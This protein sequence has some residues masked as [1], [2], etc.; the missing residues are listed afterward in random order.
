MPSPFPLRHLVLLLIVAGVMFFLGLGRLPLIEPDEGRNAEV[1]REMLATGDLITPH[2]DTFVYLDKPAVYFWLVAGSFRLWGLD[3]WAARFPSALMA[4]GTMLLT[5]FLARRMYGGS[6]GVRAGII[7]ATTPLVIALSR[8]VIFDMTLVCLETAALVCFWLATASDYRRAWLEVGMFAAMGVAT[9]TKGPVG[10]LIPL[11]SI[12]AYQALRGRL[13]ELKRLRWG[14]GLAVFLAAVL[15]WFIAVSLRH[16]D[17]PRYALWQESLERFATSSAHR[18]GSYLYYLPVYLAGFFPWS[19]FLL[20]AG[21]NRLR[22]RRELRQEAHKPALFLLAWAGVVFVFF[23]LSHSKLPGYFLPAVVPLS[24]LMARVW[25]A[26]ETSATGR[27]P[28]WLTAGFAALIGLGLLTAAAP[29][30]FRLAAVQMR[31]SEKLHPAVLALLTPSLL[32]TGLILVALGIVGRN[33]AARLGPRRLSASA[34]ALL[35]LTVPL[36][37][38]RW[39]KPLRLYATTSSSRQLARTILA[40]PEKDLPIFGY[41]CFR[42]SLMFYLR[43]PVGLVTTDGSELTSNYIPRQLGELRRQ[44]GPGTAE[45]LLLEAADL[46]A[47]DSSRGTLVM[48]RNRDVLKLS[49]TVPGLEPLWAEWQYSVWEIPPGRRAAA[50]RGD[51]GVS[52][53]RPGP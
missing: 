41:Y 3:E 38:V 10:F 8:F 28:D 22:R 35:A 52:G 34:F 4:L 1:A 16:P 2:F 49:R 43:R 33:L 51:A 13:G 5:W 25:E 26:V 27:R 42:T 44:A 17:F 24:I 11:L 32:Y 39:W 15:P 37:L 46:R 9:I 50:S 19:F 12:L 30:A 45:P 53:E 14:L 40:S 23:T 36:L 47:L 21:G 18:G 48:V 29:Q 31:A 7:M 6:A 20:L